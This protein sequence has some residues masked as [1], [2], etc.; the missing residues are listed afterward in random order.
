MSERIRTSLTKRKQEE[1][2]SGSKEGNHKHTYFANLRRKTG[3]NLSSVSGNTKYIH[4]NEYQ[5][6][7]ALIFIHRMS[8]EI[9]DKLLGIMW[10]HL[11]KE[12]TAMKESIRPKIRLQ[13]TLLF[14]C[15]GGSFAAL[16]NQFRVPVST[17]SYMVSETTEA[18]WNVLNEKYI[19]CPS[20]HNAWLEVAKGFEVSI[21]I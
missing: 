11:I 3:A 13:V 2:E 15:G 7:E 1:P 9:F 21:E 4:K 8:P 12:D 16:E 18:L 10:P 6:I 17:I 19:C 5:A 20:D 14:L